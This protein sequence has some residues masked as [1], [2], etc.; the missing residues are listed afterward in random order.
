ML[1]NVVSSN[2]STDSC[3][4][5]AICGVI[6]TLF[7]PKSFCVINALATQL[8]CT[9]FISLMILSGD[10]ANYSH[11]N[12]SRAAPLIFPERR[13]SYRATISI[14]SPRAVFIK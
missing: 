10:R 13:F 5:Y 8:E 12:T 3:V 7:M 11:S 2:V 6:I 14:S 1:L 4:L 9:N